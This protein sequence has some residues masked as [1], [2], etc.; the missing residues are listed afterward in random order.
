MTNLT[1]KE[2][3]LHTSLSAPS[4]PFTPHR[5]HSQ[6][7]TNLTRSTHWNTPTSRVLAPRETATY[8]ASLHTPTP[9]LHTNALP[10]VGAAFPQRRPRQRSKRAKGCKKPNHGTRHLTC[11]T[12][13]RRCR[14]HTTTEDCLSL[15]QPNWPSSLKRSSTSMQ[16]P[17]IGHWPRVVVLEFSTQS[18]QSLHARSTDHAA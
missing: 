17:D 13:R 1:G 7:R 4:I 9:P 16:N 12:D 14:M 8:M 3:S 2:A 5:W 11:S 6:V 15:R 10:S 18:A